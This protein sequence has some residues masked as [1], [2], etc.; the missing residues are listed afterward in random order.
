M[1]E[2]PLLLRDLEHTKNKDCNM[3]ITDEVKEPI[4][5]PRRALMLMVEE[6]LV[7]NEVTES[8]HKGGTERLIEVT[9]E[10]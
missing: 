7:V 2:V 8:L 5:T 9:T 3:L 10:G 1:D 6:L 4:K